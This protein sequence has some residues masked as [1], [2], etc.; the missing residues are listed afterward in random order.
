MC[1]PISLGAVF[2]SIGSAFRFADLAVRIAEVG[3]ENEVFVRT[4][5]VVRQ[6]LNEVERLLNVESVQQKLTNVPGKLP[7]ISNA[8]INTKSALDDIGRWVERARSEQEATGSVH[9]ETRIK[10]VF[11]DHEKLLNRTT[12]LTTCHQQLLNVSSYLIHLEDVPASSETPNHTNTAFFDDILSRHKRKAVWKPPCASA[13]N[14]ATSSGKVSNS[15][16]AECM[17]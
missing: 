12:E 9:F 11:N 16:P 3:S 2:A 17:N 4:I 6:D 10:W 1:D 14:M 8:I 13:D 7:W 5:R 15:D